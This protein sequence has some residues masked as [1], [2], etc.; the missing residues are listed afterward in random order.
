[1]SFCDLHSLHSSVVGIHTLTSTVGPATA[2]PRAAPR[3]AAPRSAA[4]RRRRRPPA[5][6][7]PTHHLSFARSGM[8]TADDV[9]LGF[10]GA[11]T[12]VVLPVIAALIFAL[13][14]VQQTVLGPLGLIEGARGY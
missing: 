8:V 6:R 5:A 10:L 13:Y 4:T 1:M 11:P 2:T 7:A 9:L 14:Y 12:F 3:R